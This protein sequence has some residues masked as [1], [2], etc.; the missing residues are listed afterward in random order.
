MHP[1]FWPSGKR[2]GQCFILTGFKG[3]PPLSEVFW[4]HRCSCSYHRRTG[5][6]LQRSGPGLPSHRG[7]PP[8]RKGLALKS[9]IEPYRF[10]PGSEG[11]GGN[12]R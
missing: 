10:I 2:E 7:H 1:F 4:W 9:L 12:D 8:G 5:A 11:G 3:S 6:A